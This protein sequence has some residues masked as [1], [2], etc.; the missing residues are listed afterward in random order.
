VKLLRKAILL[1][2]RIFAH[3]WNRLKL[4][5]WA[6]EELFELRNVH[7]MPTF[8]YRWLFHFSMRIANT[9]RLRRLADKA[10]HTIPYSVRFDLA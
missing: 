1:Q 8:Y 4:Y 2:V 9:D 5:Y 7:V 3:R 6:E 10:I